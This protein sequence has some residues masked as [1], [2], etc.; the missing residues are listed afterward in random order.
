MHLGH[1]RLFC[2]EANDWMV[3]EF[4]LLLHDAATQFE[5]NQN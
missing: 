1:T 5:I 2:V 4:R 3:P